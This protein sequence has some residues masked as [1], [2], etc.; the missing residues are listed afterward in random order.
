MPPIFDSPPIDISAF[1]CLDPSVGGCGHPITSPLDGMA[2]HPV[3]GECQAGGCRCSG[4]RRHPDWCIHLAP[5]VV[6][7]ASA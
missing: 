7:D 4:P 2:H 3:T 5:P 1:C 6:T